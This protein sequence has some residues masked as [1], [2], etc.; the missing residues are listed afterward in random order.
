M[1]RPSGSVLTTIRSKSSVSSNRPSV[2]TLSWK[3]ASVGIGG[4]FR[5]PDATC[6]FCARIA[7]TTSPAVSSRAATFSGSSQ[8]RIA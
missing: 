2:S 7:A 4:W 8:I 3:E 5:T 1:T 6:T